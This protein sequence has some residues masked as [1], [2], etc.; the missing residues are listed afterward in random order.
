M[1][2]EHLPTFSDYHALQFHLNQL[3]M[4]LNK[5]QINVSKKYTCI[6]EQMPNDEFSCLIP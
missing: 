1:N 5:N 2:N 3:G 6:N 4:G